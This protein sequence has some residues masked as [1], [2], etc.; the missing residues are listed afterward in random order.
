MYVNVYINGIIVIMQYI[1]I[2]TSYTAHTAVPENVHSESDQLR[3]MDEIISTAHA[4][5]SPNRLNVQGSIVF[6]C[7]FCLYI[8]SAL[9]C[10]FI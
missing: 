7:G 3:V 5:Q 6:E 9:R 8:L 4:L 10:L 1:P 2:G